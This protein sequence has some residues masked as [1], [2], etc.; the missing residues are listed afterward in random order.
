[1]EQGEQHRQR[2][3]CEAARRGRGMAERFPQPLGVGTGGAVVGA[4]PAPLRVVRPVVLAGGAVV[5][6]YQPLQRLFGQRRQGTVQLLVAGF[7]SAT[8]PRRRAQW[9]RA[10]MMYLQTMLGETLR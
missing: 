3:A 1:E 8:S 9:R 10:R 2:G 5:Q 4:E 7:H 6:A